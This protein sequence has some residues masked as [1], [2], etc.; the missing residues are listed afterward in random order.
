MRILILLAAAGLAGS[1]LPAEARGLQLRE[2]DAAYQAAR[3]GRILPLPT[4]R[5]RIR[6]PG[7]QRRP[8]ARAPRRRGAPAAARRARPPPR[9]GR[10]GAPPAAGARRAAGPGAPPPGCGRRIARR[11]LPAQKSAQREAETQYPLPLSCV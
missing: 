10:G 1:A 3:Q 5:A 11:P 9:G 8:P 6:V 2:Q 4:I 7:A